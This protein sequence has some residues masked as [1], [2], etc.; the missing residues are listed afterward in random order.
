MLSFKNDFSHCCKIRKRSLE[1]KQTKKKQ[2]LHWCCT[3][4]PFLVRRCNSATQSVTGLKSD[5][6]STSAT[7]ATTTQDIITLSLVHFSILCSPITLFS[8]DILPLCPFSI[9]PSS[10][11]YSYHIHSLHSSLCILSANTK[12]APSSLRISLLSLSIPFLFFPRATAAQQIVISCHG[13][14]LASKFNGQRYA[15]SL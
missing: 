3:I 11:L 7:G 4:Q 9:R 5:S 6:V 10:T 2:N 15:S 13:H 8:L 1:K 14:P 12:E